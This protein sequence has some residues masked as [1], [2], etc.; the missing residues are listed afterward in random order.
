M[1]I[2]SCCVLCVVV[3]HR[4]FLIFNFMSIRLNICHVL[5]LVCRFQSLAVTHFGDVVITPDPTPPFQAPV[6]VNPFKES[7][8]QL[9]KIKPVKEVVCDI[10]KLL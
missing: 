7:S 9:I 2:L 1:V 8:G 10:L 4:F 3:F 6:F 5:L